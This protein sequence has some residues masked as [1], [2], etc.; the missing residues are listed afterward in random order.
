MAT[1]YKAPTAPAEVQK[2]DPQGK[3]SIGHIVIPYT[4][5]LGENIRK[6][7]SKYD[8]QTHFKGNRTLRQLMVKPK[9]HDHKEKNSGV[10]YSYQCREIACNEEYIGGNIQDPGR[11]T[12]NTSRNPLPFMLTAYNLVTALHQTTLTS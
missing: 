6:M 1:K 11:D 2:E 8:I 3:P 4:Q 9:E 10:I 12:G 5:E 7:C